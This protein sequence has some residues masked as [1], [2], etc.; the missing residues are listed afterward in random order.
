MSETP[1]AETVTMTHQQIE[2]LVNELRIAI[3]GRTCCPEHAGEVLLMVMAGF[4]LDDAGD[5]RNK[6][7]A[8]IRRAAKDLANKIETGQFAILR[9]QQ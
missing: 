5:N 3:Q 1:S 8:A 6:A 2:Q 4:A 7:A 9:T